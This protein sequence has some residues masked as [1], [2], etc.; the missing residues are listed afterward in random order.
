MPMVSIYESLD[1]RLCNEMRLVVLAAGMQ[2][3]IA[4]ESDRW[5]LL[6]EEESASAARAELLAYEEERDL[7][8]Q[9]ASRAPAPTS[10]GT[11]EGIVGYIAMISLCAI[12]QWFTTN[13]PDIGEVGHMHAELLLSGQWWRA[14]TALTLHL[15]FAHLLS[16]IVFG[17]LFGYLVGRLLGGGT[18]WLLVLLSGASGNLLNAILQDPEHQSIGASTAVFAALGIVV[19]FALRP[20][21]RNEERTL[22]RWG[23]AIGG[24]LLLAFLGVGGE[25]TDVGAHVAGFVSGVVLGWCATYLPRAWSGDPRCQWIAGGLSVIIVLSAW[26][27]AI[28]V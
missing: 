21:L 16:N 9:E 6:V 20:S 28:L 25:R 8:Q 14:V 24:G 1:R 23:P 5:L 26:T 27:H 3:Q 12:L 15:D 10:V 2:S 19:A 11:I 7:N 4:V 18:G 13:G 17:A 22:L